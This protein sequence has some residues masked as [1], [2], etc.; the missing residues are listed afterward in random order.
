MINMI[1]EE[2]NGDEVKSFSNGK[3]SFSFADK[4]P[5]EERMYDVVVEYL[6]V[7]LVSGVVGCE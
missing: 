4:K 5:I 6:P 7:S 2:S 1:A 3:V